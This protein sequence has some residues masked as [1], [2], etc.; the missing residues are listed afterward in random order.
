MKKQKNMFQTKEQ[1][2]TQK[3]TLM[4]QRYMI[5]LMDFKNNNHKDAH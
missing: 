1:V 4:K 2:K 3:Q 5:Y